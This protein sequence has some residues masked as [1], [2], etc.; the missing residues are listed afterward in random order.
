MVRNLKALRYSGSTNGVNFMGFTRF[1]GEMHEIS[2]IRGEFAEHK[3]L[4][5]KILPVILKTGN[6]SMYS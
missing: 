3:T 6:Q 2:M 4:N 5:F 1:W